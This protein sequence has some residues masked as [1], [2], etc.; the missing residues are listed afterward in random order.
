VT[1]ATAL[2]A[3]D[4]TAITRGRT[5]LTAWYRVRR[6]SAPESTATVPV[7]P[8]VDELGSARELVLTGYH[9]PA[10]ATADA[11]AEAYFQEAIATVFEHRGL[12]EVQAAVSEAVRGYSLG[13]NEH[14]AIWD[15][16]TGDRLRQTASWEPFRAGRKARDRWAHALQ[17]VDAST[18]G[19]F[20]IAVADLI[21]HMETVLEAG[22]IAVPETEVI[23]FARS[24]D[25][26]GFELG[27]RRNLADQ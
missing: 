14:T 7:C 17:P 20:V 15:S 25:N 5:V 1:V 10:M 2:E 26:H 21:A 27:I 24:A 6:P 3:Y 19:P 9:G 16:L 11:V 23:A 22:Q 18:S 4:L 13:R 8:V 12:A